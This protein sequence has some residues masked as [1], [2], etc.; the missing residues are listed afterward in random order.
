MSREVGGS[1]LCWSL[2]MPGSIWV[3]LLYYLISSAQ[4]SLSARTTVSLELM[5]KTQTTACLGSHREEILRLEPPKSMFS[6][7]QA[8]PAM[9]A[10]PGG[11]SLSAS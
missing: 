2:E 3:I 7:T 11:S 6:A 9:R 10:E 4:Q 8:M 5:S 1:S